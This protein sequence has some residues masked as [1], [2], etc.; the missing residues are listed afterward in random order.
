VTITQANRALRIT[1]PFGKDGLLVEQLR[2]QENLSQP[3]H[4]DLTLLSEAGDLDPDKILGKDVTVQFKLPSGGGTRFFHGLVTRF[5]QRGYERRLHVYQAEV[6][7]WLWFLTRSSDCRIFQN[8]SALDIFEDVAKSYNFTDY[9]LPSGSYPA[10]TYCVQYRETDFNFVSRLL[11]E[12][13]IYYY[14]KHEDGRH[15]MVLANDT[16]SIPAATG[17]D[18]VPFF[19]PAPDQQRP[20]DHISQWAFE[21][22]VQP[23]AFATSDYDFEAPKNSLAGNNAIAGKHAHASYEIYDY[24]ADIAKMDAGE[25]TRLAKIRM[26]E[27][28]AQHF[29]ARGQGDAAG[30]AAGHK[31]KLTQY[32]RA[33]LN[34]EYLITA[35]S[36]QL[37]SDAHDS[38]RADPGTECVATVEGIDSKTPYRPM[39]VTPKPTIQGTQTAEVVGKAGE[40]I[41]TDKY[42]RVK[43]QFPWDR[44]GKKDENSGCWVS[45]SQAWAGKQW[46]AIHIPRIGQEVVV[47]FL[48]GDPDRPIIVG[49]TYN[50]DNMPPYDLPPNATQSGIKSR[51]SKG[52]APANFNEIRFEDKKGS[53]QVYIHAEKN[54]DNVVE[55]DE[56]TEVG[57]DRTEH[58]GNDETITIDHDRTEKVG[59]DEKISIGHDRIEDVVNNEQITI[60]V[61]RSK[62][63]GGNETL[64][65]SKNQTESIGDDR[66]LTVGKKESITIGDDRREDVA[67]NE[68]I[69][70]GKDRKHDVGDNDMLKV[71]KKLL[72]DAGDEVMIKTG[73]AS[74]L[75]KKDGTITIKGKDITLEGSGK[76]NV[77]ASSDVT[78]KGSKVSQN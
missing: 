39:R 61:N 5:A 72:I 34:I 67:K 18:S 51:S 29:L 48:D 62:S 63:V 19:P 10:R 30:L 77:K 64:D 16:S 43:I 37:T 52:G 49:R 69:N 60:G 70:I 26:Q 32:P 66:T 57:H 28:R 6:R 33:D 44:Y 42:G 8:K 21:K 11:E 20:R 22:S 38:G 68:T 73:S 76:I 74:I 7:P 56:T 31:F 58:V 24:P 55:N 2:G 3:F 23:G 50:A 13:G 65:V 1:T 71:G 45:V 40:E 9:K 59:N 78:I 36:I 47:S 12:E 15:T 53:E 25:T 4:Y 27:I 14:F 41:H 17:Y 35:S 46:G 54:Q 75:M